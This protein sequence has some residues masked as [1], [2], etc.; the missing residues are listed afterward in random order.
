[1]SDKPKSVRFFSSLIYTQSVGLFNGG[2]ALRKTAT[3]TQNNT[4]TE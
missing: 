4:N 2:S 1:M 3:Y